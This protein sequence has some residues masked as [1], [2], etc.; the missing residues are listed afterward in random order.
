MNP[1][2]TGVNVYFGNMHSWIVMIDAL[3]IPG[4]QEVIASFSPGHGVNEHEGFATLV[5]Q[6]QGPD[7][8]EAAVRIKHTGRIRDPFPS[9]VTCFGSQGEVDRLPDARRQRGD[10]PDRSRHAGSRAAC[11]ASTPA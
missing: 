8:K 1:D 5:S 4:T 7:E 2:G 9:R 6:K 10:H 3:P 11:A